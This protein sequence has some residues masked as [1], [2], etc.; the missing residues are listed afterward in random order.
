MQ[1]SVSCNGVSV[2]RLQETTNVNFGWPEKHVTPNAR[3]VEITFGFPLEAR[4]RKVASIKVWEIG[5]G[6]RR[7]VRST[8][9]PRTNDDRTSTTCGLAELL[10]LDSHRSYTAVRESRLENRERTS[11]KAPISKLFF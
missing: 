11:V 2:A 5:N 1:T 8:I 6:V 4:E 10:C 7:S 9:S 3:S